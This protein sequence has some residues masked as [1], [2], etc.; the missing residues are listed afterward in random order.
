MVCHDL[1]KCFDQIGAYLEGTITGFPLLVNTENFHDYQE[2]LY[3]QKADN[4]VT[5]VAVSDHTFSNGLPD[6]QTAID[7]I[8]GDGCFLL[9]GMSQSLML[10]GEYALD[11]KI[12]ELINLPVHGYAIVLLC[13]C[14]AILEKYRKRD[15]RLENRMLLLEGEK[16]QLTRIQVA[17]SKEEC[18]DSHYDNGLQKLLAHLERLTDLD[19]EKH[20]T[21]TVV[22]G[23]SAAFFQRSMYSVLQ[24]TGVYGVLTEKYLELAGNTE[25][26]YGSDD[27]WKWLLKVMKKSRSFSDY[28]S[29]VFY[30]TATL[31]AQLP[32]VYGAGDEKRIWLLWLGLKV[33]GAPAN[34]YLT[35][36]L[37]N[38]QNSSDLV[39]H[40]YQDLLDVSKS[41]EQFEQLYTERKSLI[42][43]LPENLPEVSRYCKNI[44]RHGKNGVYYLTDASEQE[45]MTFLQAVDNYGFEDEELNQVIK[46]GFPEL[47]LYMKKFVF[48]AMNTRLSEKD[49][50]FRDVLTDYFQQYKV[51]KI[52]NRIDDDFLEKVN[53]FAEERPFYKLQP[54]SSILSRMNKK[55]AQGYFFDALGVEYLSYILGKCEQ[56]GLI[57]KVDIAHCELPSITVRNK[58]FLHYFKTKDIGE[59][60]ELKHHSA[61]YD[62]EKTKYP[63]HIFE[64]LGIIDKEL[65]NIR[66]QLVEE[67]SEKAVLISDHGASRLAVIYEHEDKSM[68]ALEENGEH[69]GRCCPSEEDPKIPQVTYEDGY[70]VLGNYERF[71]GSRKANLEV[72]GGASLEEVVVPVIT[73]ALRP[74]DVV[75]YFVEPVV[76][77]KVGQPTAIQLFCNIPMQQPRLLVE[78]TFYEGV[79][80]K[81]QNHAIFSLTEQKKAKKYQALVYEGNTNTGVVLDFEIE[82]GTKTRDLF[83][84]K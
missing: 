63:I 8:R 62:Y 83:G 12:G 72:H 58:E 14:G 56:Y 10:Q 39:H 2:V 19:I 48:D 11:E 67:D 73:I 18:A 32:E 6:F 21:I 80:D 50:E 74:E 28:I 13:Q 45:K 20:P 64:E 43:K 78:G 66:K 47:A 1:E 49:A 22:T 4:R 30:S 17:A 16:T 31:A 68:L 76:K 24:S 75:Y 36:A 40:I 53:R 41:D 59:L 5:F 37:S 84:K 52:R 60:D 3:R 9:H 81:D 79:F 61:V 15:I 46:H 26:A 34:P 27:Q 70:A 65:R 7:S 54:R 55:G 51:Q 33:F 77:F 25:K 57:Y 44:G 38:S 35:I 69:S 71:K 29:E 82:R 42:G 23:F